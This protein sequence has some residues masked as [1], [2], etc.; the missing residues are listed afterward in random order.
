YKINNMTTFN[1]EKVTTVLLSIFA[2]LNSV[3]LMDE[4]RCSCGRPCLIPSSKIT[5][6]NKYWSIFGMI[7][8]AIIIAGL[9]YL[10]LMRSTNKKSLSYKV[11]TAI[12][13][14]HFIAYTL[15]GLNMLIMLLTGNHSSS[16]GISSANFLGT[17]IFL[18]LVSIGFSITTF[19][20]IKHR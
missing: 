16:V 14:F 19:L 18:L 6:D 7:V 2:F 11:T 5:P 3:Q 10:V 13:I 20:T 17:S 12:L 1:Q 8:Y 15:L 4:I 9:F